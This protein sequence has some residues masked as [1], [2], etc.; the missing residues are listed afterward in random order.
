MMCQGPSHQNFFTLH[1]FHAILKNRKQFC[2]QVF[3]LLSLV[4]LGLRCRFS[5]MVRSFNHFSVPVA[6]NT[7]VLSLPYRAVVCACIYTSIFLSW[8]QKHVCAWDAED[9]PQSNSC[10]GSK[11]WARLHGRVFIERHILAAFDFDS[12]A[13]WIQIKACQVLWSHQLDSHCGLV[14]LR[15]NW[16]RS[17]AVLLG[18]CQ[19]CCMRSSGLLL[20]TQI[21]SAPGASWQVPWDTAETAPT[22]NL[23]H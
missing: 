15:W 23:P 17:K 21:C 14:Q 9:F 7:I 18:S 11:V 3:K 1:V 12:T 22:T 20:W 16:S 8:I 6:S 5:S 2:W 13:A 19:C 10:W 4:K